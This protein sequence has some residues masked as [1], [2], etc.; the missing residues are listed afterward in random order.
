MSAP[1]SIPIHFPEFGTNVVP[2]IFTGGISERVQA[3]FDCTNYP[4]RIE[5]IW[6]S[7]DTVTFQLHGVSSSFR[8]NINGDTYA[9]TAADSPATSTTLNWSIPMTSYVGKSFQ[10]VLELDLG[11]GY[12]TVATSPY[13]KVLR[14]SDS[15]ITCSR[16]IQYWGQGLEVGVYYG[17]NA[18]T[19][20]FKQ[21]LRVPASIRFS[22]LELTSNIVQKDRDYSYNVCFNASDNSRTFST[23]HIPL[24]MHETLNYI[25][26]HRK[27]TIDG[28]RYV[29][30]SSFRQNRQIKGTNLWTG[31]MT[32]KI[33]EHL[34]TTT[35]AD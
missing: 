1:R 3:N 19:P 23:A 29:Y 13:M 16:I 33:A 32:V 30:G 15:Q 21:S 22:G 26:Q 5:Q 18:S 35:R 4:N 12:S 25:M 11:V 17:S 6:A 28:V 2:G 27:V 8:I 31:D 24:W 9:G 20:T 34:Y 14:P 10:M 7:T